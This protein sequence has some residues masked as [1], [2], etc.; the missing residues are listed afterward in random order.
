MDVLKTAATARNIV[1][2]FDPD[3]GWVEFNF[4][5]FCKEDVQRVPLLRCIEQYKGQTLA[6]RTMSVNHSLLSTPTKKEINCSVDIKVAG[7][8]AQRA[9]LRWLG[10]RPSKEG[11]P[12]PQ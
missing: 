6:S 3:G 7:F 4:A 9:G 8:T 5:V 2:R 10:V 1:Y 11:A 12:R